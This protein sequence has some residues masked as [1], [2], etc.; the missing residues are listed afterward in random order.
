MVVKIPTNLYLN[1]GAYCPDWKKP[2]ELHLINLSQLEK[3]ESQLNTSSSVGLYLGQ[4][5]IMDQDHLIELADR[6][7]ALVFSTISAKGVFP[8]DHPR[9]AWNVIGQRAPKNIQKLTSPI[10]CWLVIGFCRQR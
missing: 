7:D 9:F 6:L 5:A 10:D 3:I 1:E 4:G 8:E 2:D